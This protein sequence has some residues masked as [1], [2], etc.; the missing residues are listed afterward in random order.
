MILASNHD[1]ASPIHTNE[2]VTMIWRALMILA[3][4][5][6]MASLIHTNK[7]VTMI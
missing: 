2:Q 3:R 7:Q 6:D 4:N 1:M 5:H